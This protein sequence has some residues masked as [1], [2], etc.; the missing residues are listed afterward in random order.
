[1][2]DS[3]ARLAAPMV[4]GLPYVMAEAVFAVTYEMATTLDDILSRRTR[5]LLFDR[6]ATQ[7]AARTVAEIV[8]PYA[9]WTTERIESEIVAFNEI[10]EH[11]IVAG[12]IAQSDLYS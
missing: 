10:C 6:H 4:P 7:Q 3:D 11:E 1:M 2:M 5:A 9:N 12:S 8:A